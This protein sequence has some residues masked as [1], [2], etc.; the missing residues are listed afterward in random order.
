MDETSSDDY[1]G[2]EIA[3]SSGDNPR[4][5]NATG[6]LAHGGGVPHTS[7]DYIID[8]ITAG[9]TQVGLTQVGLS[10]L[11]LSQL[12]L[13]HVDLPQ[14]TCPAGTIA[15]PAGMS[16]QSEANEADRNFNEATPLQHTKAALAMPV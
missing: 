14:A 3:T 1:T 2:V 12:G 4:Q 9:T 5:S 7:N 13:N 8:H 15:C 16:E 10:Q 11:G 6:S